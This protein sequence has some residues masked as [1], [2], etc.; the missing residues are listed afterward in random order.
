[1]RRQS[2][3]GQDMNKAKKIDAILAASDWVPSSRK[4]HLDEL[5]SL[6]ALYQELFFGQQLMD[7]A[8]ILELIRKNLLQVYI[9]LKE[10]VTGTK[11]VRTCGFFAGQFLSKT[12][13][14]NVLEGR[15]D[16][17]RFDVEDLV[18]TMEEASA[19]YIG[20]I[21]GRTLRDRG[22]IMAELLRRSQ[23]APDVRILGRP[24]TTEGKRIASKYGWTPLIRPDGAPLEVW[25]GTKRID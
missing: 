24:T 14:K 20:A 9:V 12:G 18:E 8:A 22:F 1:M 10:R 13:L 2:P 5:P 7:Q 4:P 16:G 6:G 25:E 15:K 19:I 21:G 11:E 23:T 3:L 17:R